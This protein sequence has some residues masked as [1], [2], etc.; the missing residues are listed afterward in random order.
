MLENEAVYAQAGLTA[1]LTERNTLTASATRRQTMFSESSADQV[2]NGYQVLWTSQLRR[3]LAVH[4]GYGREHVIQHG[5]LGQDYDNERIDIGVD[6]TRSFSMARR[7]MF[8]FS[9]STTLTKTDTSPREFRLNGHAFLS[10]HF[11]R[12]WQTHGLLQSRDILC[13]RI[14]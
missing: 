3:D 2:S 8:G 4:A 12:T 13:A 14:L 1:R 6:F 5:E 7:T 9:T 10:K 11:R